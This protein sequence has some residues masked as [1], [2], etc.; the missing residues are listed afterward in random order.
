MLKQIQKYCTGANSASRVLSKIACLLRGITGGEQESVVATREEE[1][2]G[3]TSFVVGWLVVCM[4]GCLD[5]LV[6]RHR[7]ECTSPRSSLPWRASREHEHKI[8]LYHPEQGFLGFKVTRRLPGRQNARVSSYPPVYKR[9]HGPP[10]A[11]ERMDRKIANWLL[12][13]S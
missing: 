9:S 3:W 8:P 10:R 7:E 2:S 5:N 11:S 12:A 13:G 4:Y 6:R 1:R